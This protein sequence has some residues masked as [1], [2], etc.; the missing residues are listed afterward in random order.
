MKARLVFDRENAA[1]REHPCCRRPHIKQAQ[2]VQAARQGPQ[3]TTLYFPVQPVVMEITHNRRRW[4]REEL[5]PPE[6]GVLYTDNQGFVPG[7]PVNRQPSMLFVD[8]LNRGMGGVILRTK[9]QI[10]L[11]TEFYL[12][13]HNALEDLWETVKVRAKWANSDPHRPGYA[14]I[15][16]EFCSPEEGKTPEEQ[17]PSRKIVPLPSDYELF[18]GWE[19]FQ[20]IPRTAVCAVLN[21]LT[22]THV[23]AGYRLLKTGTRIDTCYLIQSGSCIVQV[24]KKGQLQPVGRL[25]PGDIAGEVA[26]LDDIPL[27]AHVDAETDLELWALNRKRFDA[28]CTEHPELRSFLTTLLT[29]RFEAANHRLRRMLDPYLIT[30]MIGGGTHSIIF[31]GIH[32]TLK[33]PVTIKMLRHELSLEKPLIDPLQKQARRIVALNHPNV[34]RIYQVQHRYRTLFWISEQLSGEP[35][36]SL[37]A[38]WKNLPLNRVTHFLVQACRGLDHAHRQNIVHCRLSPGNLVI[39]SGV[40]LKIVDFMIGHREEHLAEEQPGESDYRAPEQLA[41]EA[42]DHRAEIYALG[43]VACEMITGN[44]PAAADKQQQLADHPAFGQTGFPE[45]LKRFVVKACAVDP[46]DR[47]GSARQALDHL[48]ALADH[49]G[50]PQ[51]PPEGEQRKVATLSLVFRDKDQNALNQTLESFSAKITESDAEITGMDI[52]DL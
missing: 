12:Q 9:W 6:I 26:I 44:T 42:F 36:K 52:E 13:I 38:R 19:L 47:F 34:A 48:Q 4:I 32:A 28:V 22:Y 17:R 27:E 35:L 40:R 16:V 51:G 18:M 11:E 41:C 45:I 1:H 24:E 50:I 8:L 2:R 30:D 20:A 5:N 49:Y 3:R 37:M 33:L 39:T 14:I 21:E 31:K 29:R 15:G 7:A 23:K 10:D 43:V 46:V 25:H